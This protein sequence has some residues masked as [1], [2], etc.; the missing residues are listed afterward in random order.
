MVGKPG[1]YNITG[2][3]YWK[4]VDKL[5]NLGDNPETEYYKIAKLDPSKEEDWKVISDYFTATEEDY[6]K[7]E[8]SGQPLVFFKEYK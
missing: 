5:P 3:W 1:D 2:V 6:G 7:R 8:L 4:G